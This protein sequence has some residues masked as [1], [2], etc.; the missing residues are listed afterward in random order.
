MLGP[1]NDDSSTA[2]GTLDDIGSMINADWTVYSMRPSDE[3]ITAS[4]LH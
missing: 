4:E 2:L 3:V 1:K